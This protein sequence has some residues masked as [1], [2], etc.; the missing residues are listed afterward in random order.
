MA[1]GKRRDVVATTDNALARALLAKS[2]SSSVSG[3]KALLLF[4]R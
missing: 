2:K 4:Q 3:S 1:M